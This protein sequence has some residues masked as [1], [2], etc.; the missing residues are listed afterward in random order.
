MPI[1][2]DNVIA[3]AAL[4]AGWTGDDAVTAVAIALAESSGNTDAR[5]SATASGL[6]QVQ[7][8][9]HPEFGQ[10]WRDG[11]WKDPATN[12]KMAKQVYDQAGH[13]WRPWVVYQTGAYRIFVNRAKTAV[14]NPAN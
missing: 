14:G 12:A 2:S 8:S 1:V 3:G 7:Q 10:Q 11:T 5:N 4:S 13:S 9:S 6:W